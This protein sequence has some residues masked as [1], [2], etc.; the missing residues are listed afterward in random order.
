MIMIM[1]NMI[2]IIIDNSLHPLDYHA[3]GF[4]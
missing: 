1:I 3:G 2:V 4:V